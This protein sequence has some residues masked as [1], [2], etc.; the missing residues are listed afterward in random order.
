MTEDS[1]AKR[2]FDAM[3]DARLTDGEFRLLVKLRS[4]DFPDP[5][6]GRRKGIVHPGQRL[7]ARGLRSS[8]ETIKRRLQTLASCGYIRIRKGVNGAVDSYEFLEDR[9]AAAVRSDRTAG[10]VHPV[11]RPYSAHD[12]DRTAGAVHNTYLNNI[13]NSPPWHCVR[14]AHAALGG[15]VPFKLTT[16][17]T[18]TCGLN[19][20]DQ[21]WLH[22]LAVKFGEIASVELRNLTSQQRIVVGR[23]FAALC[24][25]FSADEQK[26]QA[27]G[28]DLT[29]AF[30]QLGQNRH[31]DMTA[32]LYMRYAW[33]RLEQRG[34][35]RFHKPG[36]IDGV[37]EYK[38]VQ[39]VA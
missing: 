1:F 12:T 26:N 4:Y 6:T 15:K 29:G 23:M 25:G 36:D 9:T 38:T 28:E 14:L 19:S 20:D 13:S 22:D 7:L 8:T 11:T 37:V 18:A 39:A 10:A 31:G 34:W 3:N 24:S 17:P 16:A 33:L 27:K 32:R 5:V 2:T 30:G 35:R 21:P